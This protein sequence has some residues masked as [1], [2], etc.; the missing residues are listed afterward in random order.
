MAE[1]R[2]ALA[3]AL[4]LLSASAG[5]SAEWRQSYAPIVG[6][7]T[8]SGSQYG[9]AAFLED[10]T[11]YVESEA[12]LSEYGVY[13]LN[14]VVHQRFAGRYRLELTNNF[15]NFFDAYYGEGSQTRVGARVRLDQQKY[16]GVLA[17]WAQLGGW[18]AGPFGEWFWRD[19]RGVDG[20]PAITLIPAETTAVAGLQLRRDWRD[21]KWDPDEGGLAE[22]R[23]WVH[24]GA[25]PG[26]PAFGQATA[27]LRQAYTPWGPL[28]LAARLG[29]GWTWGPATYSYRFRQGGNWVLRGYSFNRFRGERQYSG[30]AEARFPL[31][32]WF[33]G[34]AFADAGEVGDELSGSPRSSFGGGIRLALPPD[35]LMKA[36]LDYGR[37]SDEDG[38]LLEF[39][40]AF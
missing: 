35:G 12:I 32:R 29:G 18:Q 38:I 34:A 16:H 3:F 6:Y 15:S 23:A 28:T 26:S 14:L 19:P 22:L 30:S 9:A 20:N 33:S 24:P 13:G 21:N 17:L 31:W 25:E 2:A 11:R 40:Q 37:G 5:L 8:V 27:E 10:P 7:D 36:R 4:A 39:G 1:R